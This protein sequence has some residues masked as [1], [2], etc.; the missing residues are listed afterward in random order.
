M[1]KSSEILLL[2]A[3]LKRTEWVLQ[4]Y[5]KYLKEHD[6]ENDYDE[7]YWSEPESG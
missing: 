3:R 5:K 1:R 2:Q 6:L 7:W 4:C